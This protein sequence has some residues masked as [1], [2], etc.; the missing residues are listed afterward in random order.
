MPLWKNVTKMML[1]Y[2]KKLLNVSENICYKQIEE[3]HAFLLLIV[4]IHL[5]LVQELSEQLCSSR[6]LF[7]IFRY[8]GSYPARRPWSPGSRDHCHT[9]PRPPHT[10]WWRSSRHFRHRIHL[11]GNLNNHKIALNSLRTNHVPNYLTMEY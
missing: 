1:A 5:M 2:K 7:R 3:K 6:R 8:S 10:C 4:R 9:L 11:E